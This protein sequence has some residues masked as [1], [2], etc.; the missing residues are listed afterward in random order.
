MKVIISTWFY[1]S[2]KGEKINYPQLGSDS[3][4]WAF[5]KCYWDC[6]VS[7]FHSAK[8]NATDISIQYEFW[9][10]TNKEL[11]DA[12]DF[13]L[14]EYFEKNGV[15]VIF[16]EPFHIP[17]DP[18]F[19]QFNSQF[20]MIDIFKSAEKYIEKGD[21]FL[22]FDS[23]C[24]F[25]KDLPCNKLVELDKIGLQFIKN[26]WV[27]EAISN[28]ISNKDFNTSSGEI[29]SSDILC[30]DYWAGGE[31]FGL[32]SNNLIKF[33]E[34]ADLYYQKNLFLEKPL[35]TEEQLF[36]LIFYIINAGV[37]SEASPFIDRIWTQ[38]NYRT[39]NY[40]LHSNLSV[41]HLPAEKRSGFKKYAEMIIANE[42]NELEISYSALKNIFSLD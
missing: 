19:A 22:I 34:I 13:S 41:L 32:N 18:K 12:Y 36:T 11:P 29:I 16:F 33:N 6:I 39:T 15:K 4:E 25:V 17:I 23:D 30:I 38:P 3:D 26:S 31:Y 37:F 40:S 9:F 1:S 21:C 42:I 8:K 28:G 35:M 20:V 7:F 10:F 14:N 24:I 5:Q 2:P 27:G